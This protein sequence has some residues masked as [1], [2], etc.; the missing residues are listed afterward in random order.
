MVFSSESE[1]P[2]TSPPCSGL[3]DVCP[4]QA[5][6]LPRFARVWGELGGPR[7][8]WGEAAALKPSGRASASAAAGFAGTAMIPSVS[9]SMERCWLVRNRLS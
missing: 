1:V 3:A 4:A 9:S 2:F 7:L 8:A 5:A 6:R